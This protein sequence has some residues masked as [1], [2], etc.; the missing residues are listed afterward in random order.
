MILVKTSQY[1]DWFELYNEEINVEQ[2]KE[3]L[4]MLLEV[5]EQAYLRN[6][7]H[8]ALIVQVANKKVNPKDFIKG[9]LI[10]RR[11]EGLHEAQE[12][13]KLIASW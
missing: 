10:L 8:K 2:W 13:G 6:E 3:E 5:R 4:D 1:S 9:L 11:I 12:E 7:K